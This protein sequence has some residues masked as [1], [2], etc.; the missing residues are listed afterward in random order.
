MVPTPLL[1]WRTIGRSKL[2]KI[3][4]FESL[5][6]ALKFFEN[7]KTRRLFYLYFRNYEKQQAT[8]V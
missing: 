6:K 1:V 8:V 7:I 5:P 3:H 2:T 4:V